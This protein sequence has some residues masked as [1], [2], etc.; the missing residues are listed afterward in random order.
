VFNQNRMLLCGMLFVWFA[1]SAY[2]QL[3]GAPTG[4]LPTDGTINLPTNVPLKWTP[5]ANT[6]S[7]EIHFGITNPPDAVGSATASPF[8][9]WVLTPGTKFYWQVVAKN[10]HGST[11]SAVMSFTTQPRYPSRVAVWHSGIIY[12][13]A[14]GNGSWS[15]GDKAISWGAGLTTPIP[16]MGDWTGDGKVKAGMYDQTTGNWFL[17]INGDGVW[18]VGDIA[19]AWGYPGT[20]IPIVGDFNGDGKSEW[21]IVDN[22]IWFIDLNASMFFEAGD[23]AFAWGDSASTPV[24]GD[25][26]RDG[27]TKIGIFKNGY[28]YLDYNGTTLWEAQ[29][30]AFVWG[31]ATTTPV[32]GDWSGDGRTKVGVYKNGTWWLDY[33]GN[34]TWSATDKLYTF[35]DA[36]STP[37]VGDWTGDGYTEIG[38]FKAGTWRLDMNGNGVFDAGDMQFSWGS[39]GDKLL[40]GKW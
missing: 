2:A 39:T 12:A 13:D 9:A 35:G 23:L 10:T 21:G 36:A 29:D 16:V 17:D 11:P 19:F 22:G 3:P 33:D 15:A 1:G 24:L 30:L 28:W 38:T 18:S 20:S 6:T 32:L 25:W 34:T 40:V 7:F 37:V 4:L 31:D 14:D 26:N 8:M 27:R 5:G